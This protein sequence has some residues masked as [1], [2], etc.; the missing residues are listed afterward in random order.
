MW[1]TSSSILCSRRKLGG[2][3]NRGKVQVSPTVIRTS[4]APLSLLADYFLLLS[5]CPSLLWG[6][7]S[8]THSRT[9]SF[10]C[11]DTETG[12]DLSRKAE[13]D[14][15][16]LGCLRSFPNVPYVQPWKPWRGAKNGSQPCS[17]KH[18]WAQGS[19]TWTHAL[20]RCL[21]DKGMPQKGNISE[22]SS[23]MTV[24]L[25]SH[26]C[27]WILVLLGV[28]QVVFGSDVNYKYIRADTHLPS[29][30]CL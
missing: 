12:T 22:T 1:A 7:C 27:H 13:S 25:S 21:R 18:T 3:L 5:C 14:S 9:H 16:M 29:Q 6:I 20:S 10:P 23:A 28:S 15:M 19:H 8:L 2:N 30:W 24:F 17:S 11:P 26:L 4:I